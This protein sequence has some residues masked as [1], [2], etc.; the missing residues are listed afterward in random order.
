MGLFGGGKTK[1]KPVQ[2]P[3]WNPE[4]QA[5]FSKLASLVDTTKPAPE[6]PD[7]Y[8][9]ETDEEQ[10]YLRHIKGLAYNQ[11]MQKMLEGQPAYD[12]SPEAAQMYFEKVVKPQYMRN[13]EE[14]VLP[15][16]KEAYAGPGYYGSSR[17]RAMTRAAEQTAQSLDEAY[18]KLMYNEELAKRQALENA[19]N[20]SLK[21]EQLYSTEL[22]QAGQLARSIEQE[23][24]ASDLQKFLMGEEVNGKRSP[25]YHP[26]VNLALSLLGFS[27]YVYMQKSKSSG[28]GLGYSMLTGMSRGLGSALGTYIKSKAGGGAGGGS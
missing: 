17:A 11:V 27:P 5:I 26:A 23:R 24:V 9:P 14:V 10:R 8:V 13:L 7:M 1:V 25:Y 28:S 12:V 18:G 16:I 3:A 21:T 22:G 6:S 15:K 2:L 4:Q 20:R 19:M